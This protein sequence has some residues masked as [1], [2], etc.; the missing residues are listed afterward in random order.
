MSRFNQTGRRSSR[1]Y[2][3]D[4]GQPERGLPGSRTRP[5]SKIITAIVV[6]LVLVVAAG[7]ALAAE[8]PKRDKA[9][10]QAAQNAAG[11]NAAGQNAKNAAAQAKAAKA[12]Q[13][14]AA[15]AV[16]AAPNPNCTLL[17]PANPLTAQGLATPYQLVATDPAM[18]P[19][20]E[21]VKP[22]AAFVEATIVDPATGMV[23]VYHP[24]VTDMNQAPAAVPV[25]P[26]LP[27]GAIVGVWFGFNGDNLTLKDAAKGAMAAGNCVNGLKNSIFG[28]FAYCNAEAFFKAANGAMAA[29]MIKMPA[30][31]MA[32][33]GT[34]CP[35]VRDFRVV[36]MDQSDNVVSRYL[37]SGTL[38]AQD[39]MAN[40]AAM[41]AATRSRTPRTTGSWTISSTRRWDASH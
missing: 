5:L 35:T 23:G 9:K 24:L 33:D 7:S 20:N 25:V 4:S 30:A 2:D 41:P 34:P 11:Q 12:A 38:T 16:A 1:S 13:A 17:V 28:Q 27:A 3:D 19:C 39:T 8:K 6:P 22:Q 10:Q 14:A 29:G 26:A 21:F 31:Q 40:K 15:A 37:I 32:K 18:G 36:D